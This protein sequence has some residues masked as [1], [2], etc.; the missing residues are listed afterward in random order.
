MISRS[1]WWWGCATQWCGWDSLSQHR[2]GRN[3]FGCLVRASASLVSVAAEIVSVV[4]FTIFEIA[5]DFLL[6]PRI[7][8]F[9]I[10]SSSEPMFVTAKF[11]RIRNCLVSPT[12]LTIS[13]TLEPSVVYRWP[14]LLNRSASARQ[15]SIFGKMIMLDHGMR[16]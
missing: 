2:L 3:D 5:H 6:I 9:L 8:A 16:I 1:P 10:L 13:V 11:K 4:G 14:K 7:Y 12:L 15:A